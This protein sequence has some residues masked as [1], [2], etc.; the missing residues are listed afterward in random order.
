MDIEAHD[1]EDELDDEPL[2][3]VIVPASG[4]PL[5]CTAA[6]ASVWEIAKIAAV[7]LKAEGRFGDAGC[8]Y[9]PQHGVTVRDGDVTRHIARRREQTAEWAEKEQAR[10]ARQRPPPPPRQQFKLKKSRTFADHNK[11][12]P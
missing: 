4:Q 1:D 9:A 8:F 7:K 3:Q 12:A 2:H 5:P 10:R 6:P 11:R